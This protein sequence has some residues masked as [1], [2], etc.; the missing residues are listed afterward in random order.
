MAHREEFSRIGKNFES[1]GNHCN[2]K[3]LEITQNLEVV[4]RKISELE[5]RGGGNIPARDP[6]SPQSENIMFEILRGEID[7]MKNQMEKEREKRQQIEDTIHELRNSQNA[8]I[9][10][11]KISMDQLKKEQEICKN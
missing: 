4:Y 2:Q 6:S 8:E 10:K 11:S 7:R 9:L 5:T 1:M 3:I